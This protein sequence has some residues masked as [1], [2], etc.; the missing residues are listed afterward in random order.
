VAAALDAVDTTLDAISARDD[1]RS[2]FKAF[3]DLAEGL[4]TRADTA[5]TGRRNMAVRIRED[6]K[7][8][9]RPLADEL[10]ISTT[11]LHQLIH[12]EKKDR[13]KGQADARADDDLG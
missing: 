4:R 2:K 13:K 1:T 3:S 10:G 11:R 8:K 5:S 12:P 9:L 7:L 6:E